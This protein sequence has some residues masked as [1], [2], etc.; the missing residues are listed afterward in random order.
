S[1]IDVGGG[2][3]HGFLSQNGSR[4]RGVKEKSS[5]ALNIKL[6]TTMAGNS[7]G[8]SSNSNVTGKP[9]GTKVNF[10]T[11]FTQKGNDIDV[12]IPVE[13]IRAISERFANTSYGFFLGKRVAY[14]VVANY[15]RNTWGKYSDDGLSAIATKIGTP[16]MLDSYTSDICIQSWGRVTLV[17]DEG[18]PL[19]KV[20][21][22]TDY[23][24]KDE[25]ALVDN[26][27]A[28]FLAKKDGYGTQ[29]LLE[30]WKESYENA[31]YEYDPY[32]DDMYE[33]Q[34]IPANLQAICDGYYS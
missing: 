28:S 10:H 19:E 17:D 12:V 9:S 11:L 3:E 34:D 26:E 32:D 23:D 2:I 18:K 14:P 27:M 4:G 30:Q 22:S 25:F 31:D 20:V 7:P 1:R 8:E 6:G 21:Y 24:S 33:G 15:V 5:N 29:R 16:L 13:S